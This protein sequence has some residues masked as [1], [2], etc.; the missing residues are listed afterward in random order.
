VALHLY[1]ARLA[2]VSG[3]RAAGRA[4]RCATG[5]GPAGA[6]GAT[7]ATGTT[8]PAGGGGGSTELGPLQTQVN[9]IDSRVGFNTTSIGNNSSTIQQLNVLPALVDQLQTKTDRHGTDIINT[10]NA[11]G[12]TIL[13]LKSI[14][15]SIQTLETQYEQLN[16]LYTNTA[17]NVQSVITGQNSIGNRVNALE[18][19]P[20]LSIFYRTPEFLLSQYE[21]S[22]MLV[23]VNP[24]NYDPVRVF[25]K[26]RD[27]HTGFIYVVNPGSDYGFNFRHGT[28]F[29]PGNSRTIEVAI[30]SAGLFLMTNGGSRRNILTG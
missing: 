7:G 16:T 6:T 8:G 29:G 20:K 30:G 4:A 13:D 3:E 23:I 15:E 25:M 24:L 14:Q 21:N 17:N 9:N 5:A 27:I 1:S 26:A 10:A 2:A 22:K 11:V 12:K 28:Q 18:Q 19:A